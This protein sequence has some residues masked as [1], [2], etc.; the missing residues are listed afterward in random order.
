MPV[1]Q[2]RIAL[3]LETILLATDFSATSQRAQAYAHAFA[4][5]FGSTVDITHIFNPSAVTSLEEAVLGCTP[6]VRERNCENRLRLLQRSF[7]SAGIKTKVLM[8]QGRCPAKELLKVAKQFSVDM[9]VA[10]TESRTGMEQLL[11]G[12]TAEQLIRSAGCPVLTVG[13]RVKPPADGRLS[14]RRILCATDYSPESAKAAA[15]A[16]SLAEDSGARLICCYVEET[17]ADGTSSHH[18]ADGQFRQA[19]KELLPIG[20]F[21]W[22]VPEYFFEL[23]RADESLLDLAA[24]MRADLIVLGACRSSFW[25]STIDRRLTRSLLAQADCPI[26][27]VPPGR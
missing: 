20:Y 14:F 1:I 27:V 17:R 25:L 21:D 3:S 2:E 10:G 26:L 13:P 7:A 12:S 11:P 5:H 22:C 6:S 8:Y 9:I 18:V 24:Q 4:H 15:F 19:L 16:L 23:G